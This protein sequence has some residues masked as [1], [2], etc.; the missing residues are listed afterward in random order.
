MSIEL[1]RP[2]SNARRVLRWRGVRMASREGK[3]FDYVSDVSSTWHAAVAADTA[4]IR[5]RRFR[6]TH[7][8]YRFHKQNS[9]LYLRTM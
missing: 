6:Y 8:T 7:S 9:H 5:V 3:L 2:V 4:P 1:E